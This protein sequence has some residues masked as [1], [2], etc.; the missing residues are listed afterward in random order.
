[1]PA[2][3]NYHINEIVEKINEVKSTQINIQKEFKPH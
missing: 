3:Y 1:M 2:Y